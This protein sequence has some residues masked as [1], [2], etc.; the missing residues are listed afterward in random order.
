MGGEGRQLG[1]K[2]E[3]LKKGRGKKKACLPVGLRLKEDGRGGRAKFGSLRRG[4]EGGRQAK[5]GLTR[6][7]ESAEHFKKR[8][9]WSKKGKTKTTGR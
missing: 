6:R 1:R 9:G 2:R 3:A 4:G 8:G 5:E 7:G